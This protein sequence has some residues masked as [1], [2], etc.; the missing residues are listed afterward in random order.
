M[1][2]S[3]QNVFEGILFSRYLAGLR[4]LWFKSDR[5]VMLFRML[6][7]KCFFKYPVWFQNLLTEVADRIGNALDTSV[8]AQAVALDKV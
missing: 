2:K 7:T 4:G 3:F 1:K 6:I 8:A 5:L